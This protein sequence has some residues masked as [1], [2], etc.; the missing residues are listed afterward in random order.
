[1]PKPQKKIVLNKKNPEN[2][3]GFFTN[4]PTSTVV[5]I[6]ARTTKTNPQWKVIDDAIKATKRAKKKKLVL[7][8]RAGR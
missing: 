2:K 7:K 4:L 8:K 5:E 1:M 6:R 3:I